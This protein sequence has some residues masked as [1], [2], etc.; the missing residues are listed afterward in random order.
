MRKKLLPGTYFPYLA[1]SHVNVVASSESQL[2]YPHRMS[3]MCWFVPRMIIETCHDYIGIEMY[4]D[5]K[6]I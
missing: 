5:L 6:S 4:L 3:E 2:S 1:A